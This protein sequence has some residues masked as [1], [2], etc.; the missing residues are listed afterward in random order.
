[1]TTAADPDESEAFAR[2]HV[3]HNVVAL[4]FDFS[5]FLVGLSFASQSTILPA[6]AAHLGAS[7]LI[8]GAI[9]AL[10]TLGWNLPSLFAAGYT[11]SLAHKLPFVL[12][13]TVWERLPFLV[14]AAIAFFVARQ[15]PG[16]ALAL[17]L[18]ML[19]VI[20][21]AGGV[22]MPAWMDIVARAVPLTLRGRFFA[23]SSVAS[24][25][26]GLLAST[27]SAWVLAR[28]PAPDGYGICF[29]AAAICMG[30]S[31]LALAR[32]REPRAGTHGEAPPLGVYLRRAGRVLREDRNLV[33]FLL[34][35]GLT[36]VGVMASGFYTVYALR[37]Y[38]APDWAVG[39]FTAALLVGQMGG[40]LAFG[41]IADRTGHRA[42]LSLGAGALLSANLVALAAP[43]LEVF[44]LVFVLQG[45]HLAAASISGLNVLLEFAPAPEARPTYVGLG[46]TLMTPVAFGAP[47]VAGVLADSLGFSAVFTVAALGALGG[48]SLLLGRVRVPRHRPEAAS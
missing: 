27:L 42:P 1:M 44:V 41:A 22:L 29:L 16:W 12:R 34:A 32:V 47:L 9:P 3:R 23:I 14:L 2:H 24:G 35:R 37:L 46:T 7:N 33:W 30:L 28:V 48:L 21:S 17:M 6:F 40:N 13:Y 5:L 39:V 36:F 26:A 15:A 43:S 45:I 4:G 25:A 19:L 38:S 11:E 18:S 10:M 8:I 20:T 31:Y